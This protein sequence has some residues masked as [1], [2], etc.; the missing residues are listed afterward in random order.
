[1]PRLIQPPIQQQWMTNP[2]DDVRIHSNQSRTSTS[3]SEFSTS[4][5][6]I[7]V[8]TP[9]SDEHTVKRK[10]SPRFVCPCY[11]SKE[12]VEPVSSRR[13]SQ[14]KSTLCQLTDRVVLISILLFLVCFII[15]IVLL[16][17][18]IVVSS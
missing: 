5:S 17:V 13:S 7:V 1:M 18:L 2:R 12:T 10:T 15:V 14:S 3:L 4:S 6:F 11:R 8:P 16:I 9:K